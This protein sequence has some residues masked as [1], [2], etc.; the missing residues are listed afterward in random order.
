M[1][2]QIKKI[3]HELGTAF[4]TSLDSV[5]FLYRLKYI[6]LRTFVT[7]F[8]AV[9]YGTYSIEAF[10]NLTFYGVKQL[11]G[12]GIFLILLI[13]TYSQ[14]LLLVIIFVLLFITDLLISRVIVLVVIMYM[15]NLLRFLL[16][17][18]KCTFLIKTYILYVTYEF[19]C[20]VIVCLCSM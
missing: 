16:L 2:K 5:M 8:S 10:V 19:A 13:A 7:N 12:Y 3:R 1:L 4:C 18:R 15:L 20:C 14:H 6:Y 17:G 9:S 11:E